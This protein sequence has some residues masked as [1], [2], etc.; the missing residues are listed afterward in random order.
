MSRSNYIAVDIGAGSGRIILGSLS[1]GK[2]SME[3]IHRFENRQIN[4]SGH[5]YWDFSYL[6]KEIVVGLRKVANLNLEN[7]ESMGIDTWGVDYGM[8]DKKGDL[9]S[10]PF[11]YRDIRTNGVMEKV[12]N[13]TSRRKIYKKTGIQFL[14]F[15]TIYQLCQE[16]TNN[17]S[18]IKFANKLLF[19]PDLLN[20]YMTGKK[21]SEITIASTSQLLN[22]QTKEWDLELL[23][24]LKIPVNIMPQLIDSG[25][26]IGNITFAMQE[27]TGLSNINVISVGSH[28]TASAVA[29]IPV[30]SNN[31]AYL[32]SGTWS[33]VGI[34]TEEPIINSE[35]YYYGFTN[36]AGVENKN[37]FLKNTMGLW[38]FE[39][40]MKEWQLDGTMTKYNDLMRMAKRSKSFKFI[41]NPDDNIFLNP[42]NM[43][44]AI[45]DFCIESNQSVPTTKGE[46]IRGI[47][48]SLALKYRFIIDRIESISLHKIEVLYIVGGGSQNKLLNQFTANAIGKLV[49]AGPVEATAMGNILVQAIT[50]KHI[51][52]LTEGRTIIADSVFTEEYYPKDCSLW[53]DEYLKVKKMFENNTI[54]LK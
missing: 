40:V 35:S 21:V 11:T 28:D 29:A 43:L 54:D 7:I 30:K 39:Q 8:L 31:W 47:L 16:L 25:N 45:I 41:I 51:K 6:F 49:V 14:Q 4:H 27:S 3:E 17:S 37:R 22:A 46:F 18:K 33:L 2:L 42:P 52:N 1:D 48:E 20:Y 13:I 50:N 34:E 23:N 12:F 36:E 5:I 10:N 15:N 24:E 19:I 26:T 9:I 53:N 38:I 32:S 44:E